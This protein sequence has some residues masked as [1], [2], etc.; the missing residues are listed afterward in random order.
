MINLQE[1]QIKQIYKEYFTRSF[2]GF[3]K[4]LWSEVEPNAYVDNWHIEK[5]C[6]MLEDRFNAFVYDSVNIPFRSSPKEKTKDLLFNLPPGSTKSMIISVFFPAWVWFRRPSTRIICTS[7]SYAIA[8]ELA[9]KCLKLMQS[10]IYI[11]VAPS[12][13]TK[14]AL[15]N[16]KNNMG[17]Q[18][19]TTSTGGTI[20]GLHADIIINDDPNS[21]QSI[22]SPVAREEAKR[23]VSEVLP[24]RKI[25][26]R[27]AY[28]ITVQQ[29]LHNDDV[30]GNLLE[31]GNLIHLSVPAIDEKGKSFFEERFPVEFLLLQKERLG[32]ISYNAQY[33]QRTQEADGGI[34]KR[35][36]LIEDITQPPRGLI[37]FID[38]AY[39]G[40]NA[41]YN[42]ILGCYKIGNKLFLH[43]LDINKLEFPELIKRL[44]EIIEPNSKVYIEGKA[45]GKSIIQT[46]KA[47]SNFNV[48]EK[49]VVGDKMVRKH[50]MSPFFESGRI[51]IN[52][53]IK[54]KVELIEQ[55]IFDETK[56]D[57]ILDVIM[58]ATEQLLKAS[59][60]NYNVL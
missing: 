39:G 57:D 34:I 21:P 36:W 48:I 3:V 44:G 5:V 17:G 35:D 26:I 2:Y 43:T 6:D 47:E 40:K 51:I 7:Y 19:F 37:Y 1:R 18:R 20:T 25:N 59:S 14:T 30:S 41:D 55:L 49:K 32:T 60:G 13:I 56:Y 10:D 8:E 52:K 29:R 46:L 45:S 54:H 16:M 58:H 15:G 50:A 12:K 42:A 22:Y 9:S 23:F 24:S 33:L 28:T 38:S 11:S 53:N 27:T 31:A 4:T